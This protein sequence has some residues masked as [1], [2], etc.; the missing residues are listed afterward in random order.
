MPL[1]EPSL[2]PSGSV[3]AAPSQTVLL[4]ELPERHDPFL[5]FT[6]NDSALKTLK[7]EYRVI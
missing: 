7:H 2:A 1:P 6:N 4:G 3:P 5:D